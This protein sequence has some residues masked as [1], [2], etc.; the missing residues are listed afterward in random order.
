MA[1]SL[2]L[3]SKALENLETQEKAAAEKGPEAFTSFEKT[4]E[5]T[6][7]QEGAELGANLGSGSG[8]GSSS[9]STSDNDSS[10]DDSSDGS[11]DMS[12]DMPD[13]EEDS[14]ENDSDA[15]DT[16]G[17]ESEDE[18]SEEK[19]DDEDDESS[20]DNEAELKKE[21]FRTLSFLPQ[22]EPT[23]RMESL[24]AEGSTAGFISSSWGNLTYVTSALA[25]FGI[26]YT[27]ML[28][29][30]MFKIVL[31][32][33]AKTFKTLDSLF[34]EAAT[35]LTRYLRNTE[36]QKVVLQELKT[37]LE[38]LQGQNVSL[39]K[40]AVAK[41]NVDALI[42][43]DSNDLTRNVETYTSFL[44]QKMAGFQKSILSEFNGLKI[45]ASSRYLKKNF[46]GLMFMHINPQE[47][48][49]TERYPDKKEACESVSLFGMG[50]MIGQ[51]ELQA[52][53]PDARY[54]TWN[55]VEKAYGASGIFMT[56]AKSSVSQKPPVMELGALS[57]FL[58]KL[59]LLAEA[60]L[61]HQ[62]LYQEIVKSRSGVFTSIKQLFIRLCEEQVKVSFKNSVALPLHLKSSFVTQVYMTGALDLHDHT[63]RVIAN[64][65]SYADTML[66][67]YRSEA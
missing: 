1:Y 66:K 10:S 24:F 31:F 60:S 30:G 67:L 3:E 5:K 37:R 21:S 45:I 50:A 32:T 58:N 19:P 8:G 16:D 63:A 61:S 48:G 44:D 29:G 51:V 59:E 28:L 26:R 47:V 7:V 23:I 62:T 15:E 17:E 54:D 27:P 46:D 6:A 43:V 52:W 13:F 49:F 57:D 64:G 9:S 20:E 55:T 56:A 42:T 40:D 38:A 22:E 41:A 53:L 39:P 33:F 36:R 2:R 34:E 18:E 11:D 25:S 4:S 65:L 35:R 14:E 12:M